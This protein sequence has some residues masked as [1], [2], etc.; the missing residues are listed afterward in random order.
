MSEAV[1][2]IGHPLEEKLKSSARDILD[3]ILKGHRA[4]TDVKGKLAELHL[5]NYLKNMEQSGVISDLEWL[6]VDGKP[7]FAFAHK[8]YKL[9]L[10][11]KNVRNTGYTARKNERYKPYRGFPQIETQKTR[12]SKNP[13]NN[14]RAYN[15]N[16]FDIVAA[17]L[18]NQTGMWKFSFALSVTLEKQPKNQNLLGTYH[19]VYHSD[20]GP[21]SEN[22]VD[23]LSAFVSWKKGT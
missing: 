1:G 20:D 7:D 18:F 5:Y 8:G 17:C 10:E 9:Q 21:W 4:Q 19:P 12:N 3:A 6:D 13:E 22:I 11:C 16:E 14:T 2:W 23:T 15:V